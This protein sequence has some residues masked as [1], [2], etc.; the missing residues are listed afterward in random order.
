MLKPRNMPTIISVLQ[1]LERY[2]GLG[3]RNKGIYSP[4]LWSFTN[5]YIEGKYIADGVW[6]AT[7]V[8]KQVGCA[9][10]LKELLA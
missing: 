10:I 2:N 5:H 7:A 4:Y 1:H 6:S 3:Y 9:A 8:S